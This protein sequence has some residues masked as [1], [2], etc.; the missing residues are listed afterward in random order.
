MSPGPVHT[1][2]FSKT[3]V[4]QIERSAYKLGNEQLIIERRI[5]DTNAFT[6]LFSVL[7]VCFIH[8]TTGVIISC[9]GSVF[10]KVPVCGLCHG[11]KRLIGRGEGISRRI[12]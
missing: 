2:T 7:W 9:D 4:I 8:D 12:A 10:G 5:Y 6:E 3:S 1:N 11:K